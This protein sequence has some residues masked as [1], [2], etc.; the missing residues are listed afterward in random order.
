[1]VVE[2]AYLADFVLPSNELIKSMQEQLMDVFTIRDK[3]DA[4]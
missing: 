4:F 2:L 3:L 1:M